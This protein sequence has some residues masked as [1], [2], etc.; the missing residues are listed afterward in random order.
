M[1]DLI[2]KLKLSKVFVLVFLFASFSAFANDTTNDTLVVK[3]SKIRFNGYLKELPSVQYQ[4][5]TKTFDFNN[6]LHNRLN[7]RHTLTD[8]LNFSVEARNRIISGK[9]LK[10]FP[11]VKEIFE[12]DAGFV[13]MSFVPF[14]KGSHLMHTNVDRLF[15]EWQRGK[16]NIRAGRQRINWGINMISNPNDLF[17][18]YSFFDFDYEERPGSDAIRVQRFTGDLS[19]IEFAASP[20]KSLDSS[21]V[22][23]MYVFNKK[24]YDFQVLGSY[25]KSRA[26]LGL[27][28]AGN[29]KNIGF[30][31]EVTAFNDVKK[32]PNIKPF[33]LVAACSFDYM[34][35]NSLYALVEVLYNGGHGRD[36]MQFVM[37]TKPLSADNISFSEYSITSSLMYPINPILSAG[38]SAMYLVDMNTVFFSPNIKYSLAENLD[39]SLIGQFF[40]TGKN[41]QLS[42]L[43]SAVYA[44]IK[45]SF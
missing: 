16:W 25:Y 42:G 35:S 32:T 21:V 18:N 43:G 44:Q 30:K 11:Q 6:I 13:D 41:S 20:A 5:L 34:F 37:I 9:N 29:L 8:N 15:F 10:L 24:R 38:L 17:N 26:A 39:A 27:G 1:K 2:D 12:Q 19:R 14:H 45:W 33:N 22:A 31:G 7:F 3:K 40:Q 36:S 28:W 4:P 23:L